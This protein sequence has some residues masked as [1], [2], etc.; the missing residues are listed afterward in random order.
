MAPLGPTWTSPGD[1]ERPD[2]I[3][4]TCRSGHSCHN[5]AGPIIWKAAM[6]MAWQMEAIMPTV[7][8]VPEQAFYVVP[9]A[10]LDLV[11]C[12]PTASTLLGEAR[13]INRGTGQP[14]RPGTIA[15]LLRTRG[16][17]GRLSPSAERLQKWAGLKLTF[18]AAEE[19][20]RFAQIWRELRS[21]TERKAA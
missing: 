11:A 19:R 13:W 12:I 14:L 1:A 15:M 7:R 3:S 4:V 20:N 9:F 18:A 21:G 10:E 16:K 2:V 17:S 5:H 8:A 6:A